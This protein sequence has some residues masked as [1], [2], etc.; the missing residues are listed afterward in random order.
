MTKRN[1]KPAAKTA[2]DAQGTSTQPAFRLV[3]LECIRRSPTNPRQTFDQ[4]KLKELADSIRS[5]G[6]LQPLLVRPMGG[7][8][9]QPHYE[10]IAGER[11]MRAA[12]IAGMEMVPCIVQDLSDRET[13][14]RQIIEN[15]QREDVKPLEEAAAYAQLVGLGSSYNEIA[16]KVGKSV[17]QV[18]TIL[19]LERCPPKLAEALDNGT[20][21][22]STAELVCRIPN[23]Q[24]RDRVALLVVGDQT[25]LPMN[26]KQTK[27]YIERECQCELKGA[28][29][30]R[31]SKTLYPQAGSCDA[32]P[33]R[34]GNLAKVDP[35]FADSRPDICTDTTCF[36]EKSKRAMDTLLGEAQKKGIKTFNHTQSAEY[37]WDERIARQWEYWD[38]SLPIP[39]YMRHSVIKKELAEK[40]LQ[41]LLP[42]D[43]QLCLFFTAKYKPIYAAAE[44]EAIKHLGIAG[45]LPVD[46]D[47][48]GDEDEMD[49]SGSDDDVPSESPLAVIKHKQ[50]QQERDEKIKLIHTVAA[51][52]MKEDLKEVSPDSSFDKA[53]RFIARHLV[54]TSLELVIHPILFF[55][56]FGLD[57][58]TGCNSSDDQNTAIANWANSLNGDQLIA[59]M[60][61]TIAQDASTFTESSVTFNEILEFCEID[62]IED[63]QSEKA[64]KS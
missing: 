2:G 28:S 62:P 12:E 64:G 8:K 50:Q 7:T 53:I 38:I 41:E 40:P 25:R 33:K 19:S 59:M 32:C 11:R 27:E 54:S 48:L 49:E 60:L 52:L 16:E 58:P 61:A 45:I 15:A 4:E 36:I 43:C 47:H 56:Q 63:A 3:P 17:G 31:K 44:A 42:K 21:A 23:A 39:M 55:R 34:A 18:R 9:H 57:F 22:R 29:F 10:L 20:V 1:T 30:D 14:I 51:G 46:A 26:F 35:T 24:N 13:R 37:V 6:I 5:V